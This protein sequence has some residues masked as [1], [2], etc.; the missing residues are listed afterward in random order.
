MRAF[1]PGSIVVKLAS[2]AAVTTVIS[3]VAAI[4]VPSAAVCSVDL[5]ATRFYASTFDASNRAPKNFSGGF[6]ARFQHR[7]SLYAM[8]EGLATSALA[9][10]E[11]IGT[12][13]AGPRSIS[14]PGVRH[15]APSV[16][17]THALN[18][19]WAGRY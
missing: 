4:A 7:P 1:R 13:G 10:G 15:P 14:E 3:V 8:R 6:S 19:T 5:T 18:E 2:A 16:R 11:F 9:K 12:E 17:R